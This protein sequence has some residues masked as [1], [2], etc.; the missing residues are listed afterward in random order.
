M[1]INIEK[2][3]V[4]KEAFEIVESEGIVKLCSYEGNRCNSPHGFNNMIT[5]NKLIRN[6]AFINLCVILDV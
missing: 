2:L 1:I 5:V 3:K 6:L 4:V